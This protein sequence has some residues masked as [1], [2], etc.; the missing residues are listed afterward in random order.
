VGGEGAGGQQPPQRRGQDD[1]PADGQPE[2]E[3]PGGG[4]LR[5][6]GDRGQARGGAECGER[7]PRTLQFGAARAA[8]VRP[9][10]HA[11]QQQPIVSDV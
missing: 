11:D 4:V 8:A 2:R 9:Q 3:P 10:G 5:R 7:Q 6:P 1:Q